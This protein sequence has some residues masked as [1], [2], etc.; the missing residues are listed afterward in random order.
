MEFILIAWFSMMDMGETTTNDYAS[1]YGYGI[2]TSIVHEFNSEQACT[3]AGQS[4]QEKGVNTQKN[5][6]GRQR[7]PTW[8]W[9]C[10]PKGELP[11]AQSILPVT[12]EGR[13]D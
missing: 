11:K 4:L 8:N 9:V 5:G 7:L 1:A 2:A 13:N 10:V 12:E 3:D 6:R